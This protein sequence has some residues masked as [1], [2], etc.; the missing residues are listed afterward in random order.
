MTHTFEITETSA[1]IYEVID[2]VSQA[3]LTATGFE[4]EADAQSFVDEQLAMFAEA[5]EAAEAKAAELEA[6]ENPEPNP[7]ITE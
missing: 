3:I 4:G 7:E 5:K 1:T 6:M 2:G